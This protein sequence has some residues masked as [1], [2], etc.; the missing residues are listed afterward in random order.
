LSWSTDTIAA[1]TQRMRDGSSVPASAREVANRREAYDLQV[2]RALDYYGSGA[3]QRV[4]LQAELARRMGEERDPRETAD[5]DAAYQPTASS[6]IIREGRMELVTAPMVRSIV[7]SLAVLYAAD[8]FSRVYLGA[9]GQPL[10]DVAKTIE[11][12]D[13]PARGALT[14]RLHQIDALVVLLRTAHLLVRWDVDLD[15]LTYQ[16]LPPHWVYVDASPS[17]PLDERKARAIAYAE[18]T[19][20]AGGNTVWTIYVRPA[21]SSEET[22]EDAQGDSPHRMWPG[23]AFLRWVGPAGNPFDLFG[24][25]DEHIAALY[26]NGR[27]LEDASNPLVDI[28]GMSQGRC[29]WS[30]LVWHWAAPP[31]ESLFLSPQ[32]DLVRANQE[33]DIGLTWLQYVANLQTAGVPVFTGSGTPPKV[34]GPSTIVHS[35]DGD[36]KFASPQADLD[37]LVNVMQKMLQLQAL[38][39]HQSPDAVSVTRPSVQ[40]GPAKLLEQHQLVE[41]RTRRTLMADVWEARRFDLVRLLH[42][43]YGK[44]RGKQIPWDCRQVVHWG[45]LRVP[46]DRNRQVERLI[47]EVGAGFSS[48]LDAVAEVWGLDREA[49]QQKLDEIDAVGPVGGAESKQEQPSDTTS[50]DGS[51][52]ADRGKPSVDTD[53]RGEEIDAT[54]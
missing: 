42:N 38:L 27:I 20:S 44:A 35:I 5:S 24:L 22:G 3:A 8:D 31:L 14:S 9:D 6:R 45:E 49:A 26:R 53:G 54:K 30:P 29:I 36:F 23:G 52:T 50:V 10:D 41:D 33:L 37:G 1:M 32:D 11:W 39:R 17:A 46:V 51:G 48:R 40:T 7:D 47:S 13:A 28:G 18:P 25:D 4:R 21:F 16:V 15:E 43:A 19:D 12:Y 34:I 2:D